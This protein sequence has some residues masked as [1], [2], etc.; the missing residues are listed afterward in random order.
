MNKL[1]IAL[2]ALLSIFSLLA[3]TLPAPKVSAEAACYGYQKDSG[4]FKQ[5]P[6][7]EANRQYPDFQP[8]DGCYRSE[9]MGSGVAVGWTRPQPVDC[10]EV[11]GKDYA[12]CYVIREYD[13]AGKKVR[14]TKK[15]PCN[16]ELRKRIVAN[17]KVVQPNTCYIIDLNSPI[18]AASDI[19]CEQAAIQEWNSVAALNQQQDVADQNEKTK[20]AQ[21]K[22]DQ[23]Q[24]RVNCNDVD[25]CVNNN[26]LIDY[27]VVFINFLSAAIGIVVV[28]VIVLAGIQYSTAGG[29]PGKTAT[30]KKRI[31]NAIMAL[32]AYFALFMFMQ[33]LLPGGFLN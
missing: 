24:S 18:G 30:A 14:A 9:F 2:F 10:A 4:G 3:V 26:P 28:I 1:K 8:G 29:D 6:C 7:N 20:Q 25:S 11:Q 32:L 33:W 31:V 19:D 27:L 15:E 21:A 12:Q 13:V 16:A 5:F 17:E 22:F 23:D